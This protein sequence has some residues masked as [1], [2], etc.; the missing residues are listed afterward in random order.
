MPGVRSSPGVFAAVLSEAEDIEEDEEDAKEDED[1][2]K[3]IRLRAGSFVVAGV[4]ADVLAGLEPGSTA[5]LQRSCWPG[6]Q[7]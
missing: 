3:D 7:L 6:V 2:G 4:V 1:D 5:F